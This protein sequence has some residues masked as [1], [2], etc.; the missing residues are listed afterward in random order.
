M[1]HIINNFLNPDLELL[2]VTRKKLDKHLKFMIK[3]SEE[4]NKIEDYSSKLFIQRAN[5]LETQ[6]NSLVGKGV[7]LFKND[8]EYENP[9]H[10]GLPK[11]FNQKINDFII[12]MLPDRQYE[13]YVELSM[14]IDKLDKESINKRAQYE[15]F[16]IKLLI[17]KHSGKPASGTKM[18]LGKNQ[19]KLKYSDIIS[20]AKK[21]YNV[22]EISIEDAEIALGN[23]IYKNA[24]DIIAETVDIKTPITVNS[25]NFK[26]CLNEINNEIQYY[27]NRINDIITEEIISYLNDEMLEKSNRIRNV[28]VLADNNDN[29]LLDDSN[30]TH[31]DKKVTAK[32]S[33]LQSNKSLYGTREMIK[34]IEYIGETKYTYMIPANIAHTNDLKAM[35]AY[36]PH[37]FI[38]KENKSNWHT[39]IVFGSLYDFTKYDKLLEE[40]IEK[41]TFV[42]PIYYTENDLFFEW[43][44]NGVNYSNKITNKHI[45]NRVENITHDNNTFLNIT[46]SNGCSNTE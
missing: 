7:V 4:I 19:A 40:K 26:K 11:V 6:A 8:K 17:P 3:Q 36:L 39:Y 35:A 32:H 46:I 23:K 43:Y 27:E 41:E 24:N 37:C 13:K 45:K 44:S 30:N 12:E 14:K 15:A 31:C 29:T 5:L 21:L 28:Q 16:E 9:L 34:A 1:N 42:D 33:A 18:Y 2:K 25:K 20:L 38:D 10:T 22:S